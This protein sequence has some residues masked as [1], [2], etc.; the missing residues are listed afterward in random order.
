METTNRALKKAGKRC[1]IKENG[2]LKRAKS[3]Y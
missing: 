2:P 1:K 3:P